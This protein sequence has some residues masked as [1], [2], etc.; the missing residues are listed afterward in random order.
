M[1]MMGA[2]LEERSGIRFRV[3]LFRE[4]I[5]QSAPCSKKKNGLA[6]LRLSRLCSAGGLK[7][8]SVP[9]YTIIIN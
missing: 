5:G 3:P 1:R 8:Y 2:S 9:T 6:A 7:L 4:R